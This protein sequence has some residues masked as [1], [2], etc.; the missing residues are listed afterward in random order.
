LAIKQVRQMLLAIRAK[1]NGHPRVA[2]S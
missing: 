1:K 2:V